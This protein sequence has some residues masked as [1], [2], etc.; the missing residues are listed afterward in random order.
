MIQFFYDFF[1]LAGS[2]EQKIHHFA[3]GPVAASF[4]GNVVHAISDGFRGVARC[5]RKAH[6]LQEWNIGKI[7]D[8]TARMIKNK[9]HGRDRKAIGS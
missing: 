3:N 2:L 4:T 9:D 7:V 6:P 1:P 8:M 5:C